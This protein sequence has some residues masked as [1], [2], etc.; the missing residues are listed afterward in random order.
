[1][2]RLSLLDSRVIRVYFVN[3]LKKS[4]D[5]IQYNSL[6]TIIRTEKVAVIDTLRRPQKPFI[7]RQLQFPES[8]HRIS[9]GPVSTICFF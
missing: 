1:M 9:S 7:S 4:D 3:V 2:V 8:L 5:R 6:P